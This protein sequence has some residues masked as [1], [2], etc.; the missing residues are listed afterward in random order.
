MKLDNRS[1]IRSTN[2]IE[3]IR[4]PQGEVT[5]AGLMD[6]K[7]LR[8]K[9]RHA[10]GKTMRRLRGILVQ[11]EKDRIHYVGE[12]AVVGED[13]KKIVENGHFKVGDQAAL[14]AAYEE[15]MQQENEFTPHQIMDGEV[16]EVDKLEVVTPRHMEALYSLG[17]LV[18]EDG[19]PDG[20]E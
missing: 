14:D 6:E 8:P 1:I 9:L 7:G 20:A 13:G 11:I 18:D 16:E 2:D 19:E 4:G 3:G 15:L 17:I 10:L 12:H 5:Q